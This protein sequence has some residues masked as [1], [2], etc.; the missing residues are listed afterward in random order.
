MYAYTNTICCQWWI[1]R[2]CQSWSSSIHWNSGRHNAAVS[3]LLPLHNGSSR[4]DWVSMFHVVPY[5]LGFCWVG[6][7][8]CVAGHNPTNPFRQGIAPGKLSIPQIHQWWPRLSY[9]KRLITFRRG[10]HHL[11]RGTSMDD[12][13]RPQSPPC[14]HC[15]TCFSSR[16]SVED[17]EDT[18]VQHQQVPCVPHMFAPAFTPFRICCFPTVAVQVVHNVGLLIW[19]FQWSIDCSKT[20]SR[21]TSQSTHKWVTGAIQQIHKY[22]R[23]K[24]LRNRDTTSSIW[25]QQ[26]T[27]LKTYCVHVLF[28]MPDTTLYTV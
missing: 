5:A 20:K 15:C 10:N 26:K 23:H 3:S 21:E 6:T 27:C 9:A 7:L 13:G 17:C 19:I 18:Q 12:D 28:L 22:N 4:V 1:T 11:S 8:V 14:S 16:A 24:D 2:Y 25:L